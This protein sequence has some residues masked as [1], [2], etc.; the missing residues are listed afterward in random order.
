MYFGTNALYSDANKKFN[1]LSLFYIT[2]LRLILNVNVYE[3]LLSRTTRPQTKK[4]QKIGYKSRRNSHLLFFVVGQ[5]FTTEP[6][7]FFFYF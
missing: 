5:S 1:Y 3:G 7:F 6:F 4:T 2:K